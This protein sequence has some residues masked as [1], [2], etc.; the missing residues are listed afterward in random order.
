MAYSLPSLELYSTS[1]NERFLSDLL[2][3][4]SNTLATEY[5]LTKCALNKC[6]EYLLLKAWDLGRKKIYQQKCLRL[7]GRLI[8]RGF[9]F[10]ATSRFTSCKTAVASQ[11]I[12]SLC[13]SKTQN[14]KLNKPLHQFS[15]ASSMFYS[16]I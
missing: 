11:E 16:D 5:M 4:W 2:R 13:H 15:T 7:P 12:T 9:Y 14:T 8:L 3:A 10:D 1:F 6:N